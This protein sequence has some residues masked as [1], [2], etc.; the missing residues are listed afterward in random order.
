MSKREELEARIREQRTLEANK[1]GLVGASGKIGVVLR[2][3]GQDIIA[4]S[5]NEG[6]SVLPE[7]EPQEPKN[8]SE[9]M[10]RI[11]IMDVDGVSRP[12]SEEWAEMGE[13]NFSYTRKVGMHFDGLGRGMHM[14][15]QY[16]EERSEL[17]LLYK[18]YLAYREVMGEIDTYVPNEEWEGWVERL[19]RLSKDIQ[20]RG[21][22]A[23]FKE[24]AERAEK[25]KASWWRSML[26]RWGEF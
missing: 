23:E 1:K 6:F 5:Q 3:L 24:N 16:D 19:Y 8:N 2:M 22:E 14:E 17:S 10:S 12:D 15:I 7:E 20:R 26:A 13:A 21:K 4:Q 18:G 11:P 9:F 25:E